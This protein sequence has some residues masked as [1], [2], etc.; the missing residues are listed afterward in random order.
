MLYYVI[1]SIDK[2][3]GVCYTNMDLAKNAD[4]AG[5]VEVLYQ[6]V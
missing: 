4:C 5:Q 2:L 6:E 1:V 3:Y